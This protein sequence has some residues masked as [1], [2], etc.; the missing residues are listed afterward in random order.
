MG[1]KELVKF[2]PI[3]I[4][5]IVVTIAIVLI[6]IYAFKSQLNSFFDSLQARP[7]TVTMSGSETKIEL[8][9][10]ARLEPLAESIANPQGDQQQINYWE[11]TVQHLNN[12]EGFRKLGFEDLYQRL[13]S[14]KGNQIAV[15]NY[16]VND[17]E[18]NYF[19][20][21]SMLKYLSIASEKVKYLAFYEKGKF[22]GTINIGK[23]ISGLSSGKDEFRNFGEKIKSGDWINFPGLIKADQAFQTRPS[24]KELYQ[25]LDSH[26]ISEAPLREGNKLVGFLNFKSISDELYSQAETTTGEYPQK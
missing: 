14:L 18:R 8:D 2:E 4:T 12:I 5:H 9:A 19:R 13:E 17:A 3:D 15:I 7:I 6:V 26:K 23:V 16:E 22:A 10:P 25:Y 1:I 21:Q 24:V 11:D 20:D